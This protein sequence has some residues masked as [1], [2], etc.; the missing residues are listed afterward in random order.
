M[1]GR[2]SILLVILSLLITSS[3]SL[4]RQKRII[5]GSAAAEP[6]IDD[7]VVF[8]NKNGRDARI[9]GIREQNSGYYSF[10]G[11][12]YAEPPIGLHRFQ[13][14][15]AAN[16]AGDLN[17]T[18]WGAPCPQINGHKSKEIIGSEDCLF[19]NIFTPV[20]PDASEGYPV[21]IWIHGGGFKRG[22]ACQYEMKHLIKKKIIVVSIQYRLG[23]LGF[24][25][26]GTKD[27][28]G[29]NGLF[30]MILA[31]NW[32]KDYIEFFGGN[33]RKIIA[34]G[35]G[36]GA[37]S[38]LILTLSKL[39]SGIFNGVIAMSG[40][41]LS[42]FAIDKDPLNTA[43]YIG[44]NNGCPTNDTKEM[45]Q[46]LR[47]LS[48]DKLI[49]VDSRLEYTRTVSGVVSSISTLLTAGPVIEGSDDERSLPNLITE[50][51][52]KSLKFGN[53]PNIPLL[54]GIV[55]DEIGGAIFGDYKNEL[56]DKLRTIPN[57]L[58]KD[59]IPS[60]QK[61]I[62]N[63]RNTT[64]FAPEVFEKY[65][66][67]FQSNKINKMKKIAEAMGD[68]LFNAPIFLTVE[69]W[70]KKAK[71]FLYSFDYDG[72]RCYSKDFLS[73]LPI[74]DAKQSLKGINHGDDLGYIF[75]RNNIVGEKIKS[76]I[77]KTNEIDEHVTEIF[78]GMISNFARTGKLDISIQLK[79]N[80][81]LP[82]IVPNF[83][84]SNSFVSI[85][86]VPKMMENF[87]YCEMGL[88]TGLSGRLQ[89]P[90]CSLFKSTSQVV[91]NVGT[92][93]KNVI[94]KPIKNIKNINNIVPKMKP[95]FG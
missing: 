8:V 12:R 45:V 66:N 47:E 16:L 3:K 48:I 81:W 93:A 33:P 59:L 9:L 18:T 2:I 86:S 92:D 91:N 82:K 54:I 74:V 84:E 17:A 75:D 50:T 35:H 64:K 7:P 83:S 63:I 20:L 38:A 42:H 62:P 87:R 41:I 68:S 76:A 26:T 51:P 44:Y 79:N 67:I 15:K 95:T 73:G 11:I 56:E 71:A 4:R 1:N 53:F 69:H 90:A 23:S 25:S 30:D 6:P 19:L 80:T 85:N 58:S 77:D 89:S 55:K 21:L 61:T 34:F 40:T 32:I 60:L 78:T 31:V 13:R 10:R 37:I 24:L 22:S 72:E 28:P 39:S 57:Y 70:S 52:E 29:N 65:F 14:P 49:E 94:E 88:W 46:C 5:G 27:L 36:T 43:K